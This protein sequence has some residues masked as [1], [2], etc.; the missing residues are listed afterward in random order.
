MNDYD[1]DFTVEGAGGKIKLEYKRKGLERLY[2]KISQK[3][4]DLRD[5]I[6]NVPKDELGILT[7]NYQKMIEIIERYI[8]EAFLQSKTEMITFKKNPEMRYESAD[9]LEAWVFGKPDF[10]DLMKN[11]T[12]EKEKATRWQWISIATTAGSTATTLCI[13]GGFF[14]GGTTWWISGAIAL[15][16]ISALTGFYGAK[17]E[18]TA[19]EIAVSVTTRMGVTLKNGK[20]GPKDLMGCFFDCVGLID[21]LLTGTS[22]QTCNEAEAYNLYSYM[23]TPFVAETSVSGSI[24]L[25][26]P[27]II[28]SQG[29]EKGTATG[30]IMIENTGSK[31]AQATGQITVYIPAGMQG[32]VLKIFNC[33]IPSTKI[34]PG[35]TRI[36]QF[37]YFGVSSSWWGSSYLVEA[38]VTLTTEDGQAKIGP[39]TSRFYVGTREEISSLKQNEENIMKATADYSGARF[40]KD[41]IV[42]SDMSSFSLILTS[43]GGDFDLHLYDSEGKHVGYNYAEDRVENQIAGA[44][45][46]GKDA[47]ME[48]ITV[49]GD[50]AGRQYKLKVSGFKKVKDETFTVRLIQ[51]P[52]RPPIVTVC[53]SYMKEVITAGNASKREVQIQEIGGAKSATVYLNA[54]GDVAQWIEFSRTSLNVPPNGF[55]SVDI[56]INV[57]SYAK[58]GTTYTGTLVVDAGKAG[59][60]MIPVELTIIKQRKTEAKPLIS[61]TQLLRKFMTEVMLSTETGKMVT[62]GLYTIYQS[63]AS[64]IVSL[65]STHETLKEAMRILLFPL[66]KILDAGLYIYNLLGLR[67]WNLP[68]IP[69][70]VLL[71]FVSVLVTIAYMTPLILLLNVVKKI[72][73]SERVYEMMHYV[74][75]ISVI[76]MFAAWFFKFPTLMMIGGTVL[77]LSTIIIT[78][79]AIV[80][81][82]AELRKPSKN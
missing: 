28:I 26:T 73:V 24:S 53:P 59:Q 3:C 76:A 57:P 34:K 33:F 16:G 21:N 49:T 77:I 11:A 65:I 41:F 51:T 23:F 4:E 44:V 50:V 46:S 47:N 75:G 15:G 12:K 70:M 55:V 27:N 63:F 19:E 69:I 74:W 2:E 58:D 54:E 32:R 68:D 17:H 13:V 9:S 30:Q 52:K 78:T 66:I 35:E 29:E 67:S 42:S 18:V 7:A 45:Y 80:M 56:T 48:R 36:F 1:I 82:I 31:E 40:E 38:I 79:L 43:S 22:V 5:K 8:N 14:T 6:R 37:P 72:D 64:P 25:S 10:Y 81:F 71:L 20:N 61:E 62:L 39:V 60:K